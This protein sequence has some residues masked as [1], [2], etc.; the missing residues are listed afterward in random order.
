MTRAEQDVAFRICITIDAPHTQNKMDGSTKIVWCTN[1]ICCNTCTKRKC[2]PACHIAKIRALGQLC[3]TR[4][5]VPAR[6]SGKLAKIAKAKQIYEAQLSSQP[7]LAICDKEA[8][9]PILIGTDVNKQQ[10]KK[11]AAKKRKS[12]NT[13]NKN[14]NS[15]PPASDEE[16]EDVRAPVSSHPYTHARAYQRMI[17]ICLKSEACMVQVCSRW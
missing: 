13:K 8:P 9:E 2:L 16:E 6:A 17:S 12:M 1:T 7:L 3:L 11:A 5:R 4:V 14:K 10:S 15:A